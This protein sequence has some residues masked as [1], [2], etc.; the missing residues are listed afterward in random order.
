MCEY[1]SAAQRLLLLMAHKTPRI[2]AHKTHWSL[3]CRAATFSSRTAPLLAKLGPKA[4]AAVL[5]P[6]SVL[7]CSCASG[8]AL[9]WESSRVELRD[10]GLVS[11]PTGRGYLCVARTQTPTNTHTLDQPPPER[12]VRQQTPGPIHAADVE[13]LQGA[14]GIGALGCCCCGLLSTCLQRPQ[15]SA[16]H[17]TH[18]PT[19]HYNMK[20]FNPILSSVAPVKDRFDC[21]C[22]VVKV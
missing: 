8:A 2:P 10:V 17:L 6:V 5:L 13:Q 12:L 3:G 1:E 19:P 4:S 18:V 20:C 16:Q 22:R 15:A 9:L 14:Q 11:P 7:A 21:N